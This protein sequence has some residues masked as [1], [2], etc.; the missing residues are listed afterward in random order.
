MMSLSMLWGLVNGI[1]II[2]YF[3]LLNLAIP[4]NVLL[5]KEVLYE[6]ATFD[7]IPLD[8]VTDF[9]DNHIGE[10]DNNRNVTLGAQALQSGFDRTN[11]IVNMILPLM[12]VLTTMAVLLIL[13]IFSRCHTKIHKLYLSVKKK[14]FWNHFIRLFIEEYML[15]CLACLIKLYA[16]DL[17][18]FYEVLNSIFALFLFI[19]TIVFPILV[20]L[21]LLKQYKAGNLSKDH[22]QHDQFRQKWGSLVLDLQIRE[23]ES[24]FFTTTFMARRW[25]VALIIVA[26]VQM[27]WAQIQLTV[28]LNTLAMIY[29]GQ[30][31]PYVLPGYNKLQLMNEAVIIVC[32]YYLFLYTDYLPHIEVRYAVGWFNIFTIA[33]A[34]LLN[35]VYLVKSNIRDFIFGIKKQKRKVIHRRNALVLQVKQL[36]RLHTWYQSEKYKIEEEKSIESDDSEIFSRQGPPGLASLRDNPPLT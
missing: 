30:F 17:S 9:L 25:I 16:F 2:A 11:P 27:S 5:V 8:F 26:L 23:K 3:M 7:L 13:K 6:I 21:F 22:H 20:L 1:Q 35:F 4:A 32:S 36:Q 33:L 12:I 18:N 31:R 24:L 34:V 19:L 10:Y 15:I 29:Q 28:F 14:V